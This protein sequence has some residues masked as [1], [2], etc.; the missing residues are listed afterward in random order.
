MTVDAFATD[1]E[2]TVDGEGLAVSS[3]FQGSDVSAA[4]A[5]T[6][7]AAIAKPLIVLFI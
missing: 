4:L 3:N 1:S 6:H 7:S 2:T 5:E